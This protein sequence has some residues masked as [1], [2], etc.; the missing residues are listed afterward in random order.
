MM[1][2]PKGIADIRVPVPV[3]IVVPKP[4][5]AVAIP[6]FSFEVTEN[7]FVQGNDDSR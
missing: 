7:E 3:A 6:D 1:K 5:G 2:T 4:F